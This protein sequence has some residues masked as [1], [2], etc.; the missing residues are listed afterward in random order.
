MRTREEL[1]KADRI[2]GFTHSF[3]KLFAP[4]MSIVRLICIKQR[5]KCLEAGVCSAHLTPVKG[6]AG[7]SKRVS[8]ASRKAAADEG[9]LMNAGLDSAGTESV[10]LQMAA[11]RV[12]K[13]VSVV[14]PP[15]TELYPG[16]RSGGIRAAEGPDQRP[17]LESQQP[18]YQST[19]LAHIW[20]LVW[21]PQVLYEVEVLVPAS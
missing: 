12:D 10:P 18:N 9:V 20:S 11:G 6:E 14:L 3:K 7:G 4:Q 21:G 19:G 17:F 5:I 16:R 15:W 13:P 2:I 8:S 1:F